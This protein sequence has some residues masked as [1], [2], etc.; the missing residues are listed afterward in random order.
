MIAPL[1]PAFQSGAGRWSAEQIHDTV[2]AIVRQPEF[3]T[4]LRQSL[5]GRVLR[6]VADRVGAL[7]DLLRGSPSSRVIVITAVVLIILVIVARIIVTRRIDAAGVFGDDDGSGGR[8]DR[9]RDPWAEARERAGAG[10]YEAATHFLYAA[11]IETLARDGAITHHPSKT[12][13]DYARE[14][15]RRGAAGSRDFRSFAREADRVIFGSLQPDA[16]SYERLESAAAR[17]ARVPLAA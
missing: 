5:A 6:Y 16:E 3:A 11:V 9:R 14:L 17:I 7:I 2:A 1:A 12:S 15:A 10:D 13:G 4:P 8:R